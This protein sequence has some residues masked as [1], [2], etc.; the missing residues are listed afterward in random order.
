MNVELSHPILMLHN[1]GIF[2]KVFNKFCVNNNAKNK[3]NK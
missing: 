3:Y 1:S 2:K